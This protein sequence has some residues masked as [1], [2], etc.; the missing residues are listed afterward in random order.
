MDRRTVYIV[1][2]VLGD[3]IIGFCI[4]VASMVWGRQADVFGRWIVGAFES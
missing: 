1:G 3:L 4:F 2:G